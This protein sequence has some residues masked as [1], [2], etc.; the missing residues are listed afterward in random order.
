MQQWSLWLKLKAVLSTM[1]SK[2]KNLSIL[3]PWMKIASALEGLN[4]DAAVVIVDEVKS[5]T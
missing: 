5:R 2:L 1:F 3:V 4:P